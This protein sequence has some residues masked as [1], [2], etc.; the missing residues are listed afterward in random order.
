MIHETG[1]RRKA[2]RQVMV[3]GLSLYGALAT[4]LISSGS[5]QRAGWVQGVVAWGFPQGAAGGQTGTFYMPVNTK[6]SQL[7]KDQ[8]TGTR[9]L[10]KVP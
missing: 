10:G 6:T 2:E 5:G 1:G 4:L 7:W 9:G 3:A 8:G